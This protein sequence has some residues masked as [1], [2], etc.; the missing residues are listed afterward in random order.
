MLIQKLYF[1]WEN[2]KFDFPVKLGQNKSEL[3]NKGFVKEIIDS[4]T[5]KTNYTGATGNPWRIKFENNLVTQIWFNKENNFIYD[6]VNL[7]DKIN[8]S[9]K[10][11]LNQ[12]FEELSVSSQEAIN[13]NNIKDGVLYVVLGDFHVKMI[14]V[15]G[16]K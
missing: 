3:I 11:Y 2:S 9:G 1:K 6:G 12:N 4:K 13:F 10:T 16:K 15:I 8:D 5:G 14:A 7:K